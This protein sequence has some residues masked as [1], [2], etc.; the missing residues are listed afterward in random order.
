[1]TGRPRLRLTPRTLRSRLTCG[2]LVLLAVSSSA[3]SLAASLAVRGVLTE[4][5]D[6]QLKDASS[7]FPASLK[8]NLPGTLLHP[9]ERAD[10]R[11]QALGTFG[12][13]LSDGKLLEAAVVRAG[14]DSSVTSK[15]TDEAALAGVPADGAGHTLRLSTLGSYRVMAVD[16]TDGNVLITGIPL[17][18]VQDA[19]HK[20]QLIGA[21]FLGAALLSTGVVGTVWVRRS[22]RPLNQVAATAKEVTRTPLAHGE[23]VLPP[24]VSVKNAGSEVEHVAEALNH[25]IGHVEDALSQ[26]QIGQE[27]L[28]RFAADASH[29]LRTPVA[30]IR[31]HAELALRYPAAIPAKVE[32]ALQRVAAES[33]RMGGIVD[34]LLLLARLDAGRAL[35]REPVDMSR[36]VLD[37]TDDAHAMGPDHVWVLDLP[38]EPITVLGDEARLQQVLAN[39]LANARLHTPAGTR[40]TIRLRD[41]TTHALLLVTDDGPGI[42]APLQGTLFE[43]FARGERHHSGDGTGAGLGLSIVAA[44]VEA[45]HGAITVDTTQGHTAFAV[46]LLRP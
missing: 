41:V 10:A 32:R 11:G 20:I 34:D 13:R 16:G 31:G 9:E 29:E 43:R 24:G 36:L 14:T 33:V 12:A 19:V 25:M 18:G 17:A 23:V 30:A 40:V 37:S 3:V 2:L 35:E 1:M 21:A 46:T 22:L 38:E 4:N 39:L 15:G 6:Q 27:R 42:P 5:V 45:H 7:R 26:R 44:V 8:T 28:R